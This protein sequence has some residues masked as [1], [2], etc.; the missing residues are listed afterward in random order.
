MNGHPSKP[1]R[2]RILDELA[3]TAPAKPPRV[4]HSAIVRAVCLTGA[5]VIMGAV[6][7]C[8]RQSV[9]K[10]EKRDVTFEPD[11]RPLPREAPV[12]SQP[13]ERKRKI[14]GQYD[15]EWAKRRNPL[16]PDRDPASGNENGPGKEREL[17][18]D[19]VASFAE[20]DPRGG[21]AWARQL[22]VRVQREAALESLAWAC[23]TTDLAVSVEALEQL[24]P[25]AGRSRLV[26]HVVGEWAV[27][28]P[29]GAQ[30]WA[31]NRS[32]ASERTDALAAFAVAIAE[33]YPHR[34]ATIVADKIQA[35]AVQNRA[36]VAV[37]QRW[38][39]S[40][41][42]AAEQWVADF[43]NN[44]LKAAAVAVIT[45]KIPPD[46]PLVYT[47]LSAKDSQAR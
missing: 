38:I 9:S 27:N 28:D 41:R 22:P 18:T 11:S 34:A 23:A 6:S 7:G 5:A 16:K 12:A 15:D 13:S 26:A 30:L 47:K 29:D 35:G 3:P 44:P 32:D 40:D 31:E 37:I 1:S 42:N 25:G 17:M 8:N 36:A 10:A 14:E 19:T 45:G 20:S 39:Q 46:P 24:P 2:W 4:W 43:P 33:A 21:L